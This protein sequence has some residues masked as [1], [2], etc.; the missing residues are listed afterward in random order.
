[1]APHDTVGARP[2]IGC[3]E[4]RAEIAEANQEKSRDATDAEDL[5]LRICAG[6]FR[7]ALWQRQGYLNVTQ[8]LP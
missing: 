6:R 1:M 7:V 3:A 8:M 2:D 5:H 4:G